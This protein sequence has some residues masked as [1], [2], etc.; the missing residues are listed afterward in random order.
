MNEE[1]KR[2]LTASLKYRTD[3]EKEKELANQAPI[4]HK[5]ADKG[6]GHHHKERHLPGGQ[7][8]P[9]EVECKGIQFAYNNHEIINLL[10]KRGTAIAGCKWNDVKK[11]DDK[12]T[13]MVKD[14]RNYEKF[15]TPVC[16]FVTFESD[17][18]ALEALSYSKKHHWYDFRDRTD[19]YK[20]FPK[21]MLLG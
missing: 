12:L 10:K 4:R 9:T 7:E 14:E 11:Y 6:K 18:G 19:P 20:G 15:T 5:G 17:D 3:K 2:I 8:K 21:Q 16:A 13:E 1:I